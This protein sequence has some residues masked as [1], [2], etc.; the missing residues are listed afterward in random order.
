MNTDNAEW[1]LPLLLQPLEAIV[2][3]L[4]G[5]SRGGL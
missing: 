2:T 5:M 4:R 1:T 3:E